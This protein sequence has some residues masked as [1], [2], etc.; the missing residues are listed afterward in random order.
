MLQRVA[1]TKR[2]TAAA[3][4]LYI[5]LLIVADV[6]VYNL[7]AASSNTTNPQAVYLYMAT[8]FAHTAYGVCNDVSPM[9]SGEIIISIC[10]LQ[11][12]SKRNNALAGNAVLGIT[13]KLKGLSIMTV[14]GHHG[15]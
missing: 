4:Q 15:R 5:E 7:L 3:N 14:G 10:F 9:M 1:T 2:Q 8:F 6:T 12:V 11:Q 13:I